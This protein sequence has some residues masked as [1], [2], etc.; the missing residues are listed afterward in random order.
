ME[1]STRI[2]SV[3]KIVSNDYIAGFSFYAFFIVWFMYFFLI[4]DSAFKEIAIMSCLG[5]PIFIWRVY[6]FKTL[7]ERGLEIRGTITY[8]AY[9]GRGDAVRYEYTFQD[10]KYISGN[11]LAS[12][13]LKDNNYNMGDEVALLVDPKK[14]KKAVIKDIYF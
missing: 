1:N 7:Y 13:S 8:A 10:E 12:L 14:P 5:I 6:F 2:F 3:R 4:H 11:A 9:V